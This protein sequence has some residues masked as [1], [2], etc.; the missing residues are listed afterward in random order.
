MNFVR[1]VPV[2]RVA[3]Y[4]PITVSAMSEVKMGDVVNVVIESFGHGVNGRC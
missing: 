3:V 2:T 4:W 1:H